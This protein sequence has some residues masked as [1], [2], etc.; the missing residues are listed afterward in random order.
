MKT[1]FNFIGRALQLFGLLALPSAIWVAEFQKNEAA[2]VTLFVGSMGI[3][4]IGW[5]FTR[6]G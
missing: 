6:I 3:F 4:F 2:A 5:V 1:I